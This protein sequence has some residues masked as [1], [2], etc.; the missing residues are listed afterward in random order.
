MV[1]G[2]GS[3]DVVFEGVVDIQLADKRRRQPAKAAM[4]TRL[5]PDDMSGLPAYEPCPLD[6]TSSAKHVYINKAWRTV[7]SS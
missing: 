6:Q 1:V 5:V 2:G 7:S 3:A 4:D